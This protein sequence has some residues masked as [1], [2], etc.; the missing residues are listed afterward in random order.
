MRPA[1]C[2]PASVVSGA[3]PRP[4][5]PRPPGPPR[6]VNRTARPPTTIPAPTASW[7]AFASLG[8]LSVAGGGPRRRIAGS[9]II[10]LSGSSGRRPRKTRRQLTCRHRAGERGAHDARQH[11]CAGHESKHP[12]A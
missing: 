4:L 2:L 9:V 8:P 6:R 5:P 7:T 12:R 10:M 3:V 1:A 11:P